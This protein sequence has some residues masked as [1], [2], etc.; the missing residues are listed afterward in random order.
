MKK[1]M[2][3]TIGTGRGVESGIAA[4]IRQN[5]PDF[6]VFLA[7]DESKETIQRVEEV[8]GKKFSREEHEIKIIGNENDA[9][10]CYKVAK[11]AI[12]ELKENYDIC[13]DFTSGTKA[14]TGGLILAAVIEGVPNLVYVM[15]E[16]DKET[17]RVISG[18]ERVY[19]I[20]SPI[21]ILVD[22]KKNLIMSMF[23]NYQF[24]DCLK[25]IQDVKREV[26]PEKLKEFSIDTLETIVKA[27]YLWDLFRHEEAFNELI[28]LKSKKL[29]DSIDIAQLNNNK[30]FLGKLISKDSERDKLL[31]ADI[32]CNA[33]RRIEE[34]K[35]DDAVARLYRAVEF[36][37]QVALKQKG[38]NT[39]EF[40]TIDLHALPI[41]EKRKEEYEKYAEN[42]KIKL[43]LRA[44]YELL[45]DL[46]H[47]L[48]KKFQ[49]DKALQNL[50]TKRNSSILA[51]GIRPV[52]ESDARELYE[53]V[54]EY[55]GIIYND[56]YEWMKKA[57]FIKLGIGSIPEKDC[58]NDVI[59]S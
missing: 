13:V 16:R 43:G 49:D 22:I 40:Y 25:T 6:I 38:V 48:G 5:N 41:D 15:G 26:S 14:M 45:K 29:G 9:E 28:N 7:T 59:T 8:L 46:D 18:T 20:P 51:H 44:A 31:L 19:A 32:I 55:A 52:E 17:G 39:E 53:K 21:K 23:N 42:G 10:E 36:I 47:H 11:D 24:Y 30:E 3:L 58:F 27:Y 4:S 54:I 1:A 12:K 35:Y 50:L 34:G 33:E 2:V 37:G 56:I 57:S